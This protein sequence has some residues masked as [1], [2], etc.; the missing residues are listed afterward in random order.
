MEKH[1][2]WESNPEMVN[3]EKEMRKDNPNYTDEE[4]MDMMLDL[5]ASYLNDEIA[6]LD[7]ELD[8]SIIIIASLGLWNGR[9]HGYKLLG[10]NI[11]DCLRQQFDDMSF[12]VESGD[13]QGTEH[14]HDGT[15]YY[16][17]RKLKADLNQ[18]EIDDFL[19]IAYRREPSKEEI[20]KY[21]ES[22]APYI[23]NVYGWED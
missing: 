10:S 22:L 4:I 6:N 15:N 12:Y 13:F 8:S 19:D 3:F 14:H 16:L 17:Y 1:I 11:N 9:K 18:K 7:I 5:N 20:D 2:I 23:N 21:T